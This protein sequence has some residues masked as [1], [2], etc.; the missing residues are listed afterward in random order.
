[1]SFGSE[2]YPSELLFPSNRL[3]PATS[4]DGNWFLPPGA[5]VVDFSMGNPSFSTLLDEGLSQ[6]LVHNNMLHQLSYE[7]PESQNLVTENTIN[8]IVT[9][10]GF[11]NITAQKDTGVTLSQTLEG[12]ELRELTYVSPLL[13]EGSIG[14]LKQYEK[15]R[16]MFRGD[17]VIKIEDENNEEMQTEAFSSA[18][19]ISVWVG[20]PVGQ[21]RAHGIQFKITGNC[22]VNSI[23][24]NWTPKEAQ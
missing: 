12:G 4:I 20:I 9:E 19:L 23:M 7:V 21:N 8:N 16:V 13:T 6:L 17:I 5:L 14:T 18:K 22:I 24:Y 1:M 2:L 10:S 11:F 15:I 3:Y